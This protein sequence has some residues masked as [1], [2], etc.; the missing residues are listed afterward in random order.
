[1]GAILTLIGDFLLGANP[2]AETTGSAMV[3]MFVDAAGNSG[4][5]MALGGMLGAIGIPLE[6]VA[7]FQ[8]NRILKGNGG[9]LSHIYRFSILMYIGLA[10]AGTHLGCAAIAM[11]YQWVSAADPVL[12]VDVAEK[13]ASYFMMP[14]T[15]LFGVLLLIALIYQTVL[16]GR[17]KTVY[18]RHAVFYNM[19]FGML[20][21]YLLAAVI[22]NN[23]VGNG[24]ATGAVSIGHIWMFGMMRLHFPE[25]SET[26]SAMRESDP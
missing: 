24:I 12:A 11:I 9:I 1:M 26:T 25:E 16:I 22:G 18:P 3:D 6:G 21:A 13:Y 8:I 15:V 10:G 23:V 20:A 19:V 7:Y 14:P 2:A 5:R 17:G 4:L